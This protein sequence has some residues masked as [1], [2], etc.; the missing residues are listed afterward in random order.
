MPVKKKPLEGRE[1]LRTL[2]SG[3]RTA[4]TKPNIHG[5]KPHEKQVDFHSSP[6]QIR[7]FLG[8]NRSG[9]TVG[10]ACES[11]WR[12]QGNHPYLITPQPP[13]ALRAVA[14]DFVDG[15]FKIMLPQIARWLPPSALINGSWTDSWDSYLKTLTLAN[16]STIE[17]M[18]YEQDLEKF[19][20][21]SRHGIW[22]DEE[23]PKA[24]Y[25]EN[26]LRLLDVSGQ[27][28]ITM[29]PVEGMTWLYD[30]L[31]LAA[32][33]NPAIHVTEV[34]MA[35]N[36]HLNHG[37]LD[38]FLSTLDQDAKDARQHG[39]FVQIGGLIYKNFSDKNVI[40]PMIP[41]NDW[42]HVAAMDHGL[43]NPT[44]WLW[45]AVDHDGR[46]IIYDEHYEAQQLVGYHAQM[47]RNRELARGF[48]PSY[49]VGDPSIRNRDPITGTSVQLEY[50]D[51]SVAIIPGNNDVAAGI[52]RVRRYIEGV[53][54]QPNLFITRNC[55]NLIEELNRYRWSTWAT[56]KMN[57]SKNKKED[58]HKRND[59]AVDALRYLI[60][61]RPLLDDGT[62]I[63]E[64]TMRERF[65]LSLPVS[66]GV[67]Y[68]S[69]YT[70]KRPTEW[71]DPVMGSDW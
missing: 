4:A 55:I 20:G 59:H 70:T 2:A 22:F 10:G 15:V 37:E 16:G 54:G 66:P 18:S 43:N 34:D 21:T 11:C 42:L 19:A 29:T 35:E 64:S 57:Y 41:P 58:P 56:K 8:G 36:P 47:V 61:S 45:G 62:E 39:K 28:W 50:M 23:P 24:I 32:K 14:V 30:D 33:T 25:E 6:V 38:M 53:E 13:V 52:N 71:V 51:Y 1:L 40:D 67:A 46:I 44:A 17:F 49:R 65:G 68:D 48:E 31:Y 12:L 9:K 7:L 26:L 5:Y 3:L 63:V 69:E 27:M 60:A